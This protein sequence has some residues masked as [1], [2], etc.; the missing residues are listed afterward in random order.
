MPLLQRQCACGGGCPRCQD[1]L[2]I[3]TKLK[4]SE[5]GDKYEQEADRVANEV[6]RMPEPSVQ[7]QVEPEAEEEKMVQRKVG[8]RVSPLNSKP[9]SSKVRPIVHEVLNSPGQPH[10]HERKLNCQRSAAQSLNNQ[11]IHQHTVVQSFNH[12]FLQRKYVEEKNAGCGLCKGDKSVGT[13]VH[14]VVQQGAFSP[15]VQAEVAIGASIPNRKDKEN[16]RLDLARLYVSRKNPYPLV[17]VEIGEIKPYNT[18]GVKRGY[19][20]LEDYKSL[21]RKHIKE[22]YPEF[23]IDIVGLEDHPNPSELPYLETQGCPAQIVSV[24]GSRDSSGLYLYSC[25]PPRSKLSKKCCKKSQE[26]EQPIP[27]VVPHPR[28]IAETLPKPV[29]GVGQPAYAAQGAS[30]GS[31]SSVSSAKTSLRTTGSTSAGGGAA[32]SATAETTGTRAAASGSR[33]ASLGRGAARLATRFSI[34]VTITVVIAWKLADYVYGGVMVPIVANALIEHAYKP[35]SKYGYEII[36]SSGEVN[37]ILI[38]L[39]DAEGNTEKD[40]GY[41]QLLHSALH[42]LY[43]AV[44]KATQTLNGAIQHFPAMSERVELG[45]SQSSWNSITELMQMHGNNFPDEFSPMLTHLAGLLTRLGNQLLDSMQHLYDE[46]DAIL[47]EHVRYLMKK[48]HP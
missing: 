28:L 42:P 46:R 6:M 45:Q 43:T 1:E 4:I 2:G 47:K 21:V 31:L 41:Q 27:I 37:D 22:L 20:D 12:A 38:Q 16:G 7:R 5:P 10:S 44:Y 11:S 17:T 48:Y 32:G 15:R 18:A 36:R 39:W 40:E 9:V 35:M 14:K 26:Q 23:I 25:S 30:S 34:P 29:T 13:E 33:L 24:E 3:Q 19:K 8:D